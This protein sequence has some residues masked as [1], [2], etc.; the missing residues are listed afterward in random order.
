MRGGEE[1]FRNAYQ[2]LGLGEPSPNGHKKPEAGINPLLAG[3]VLLDGILRDGAPPPDEHEKGLLIRGAVHHLYGP[4]AQG[5]SWVTLWLVAR[6]LRRGETVCYFDSE[7]GKRITVERLGELGVTPE[8][9]ANLHYWPDGGDLTLDPASRHNYREVLEV[10][11]PDLIL[12]DALIYFL[13]NAGVGENDPDGI[14]AWSLAFTR[15]ARE[16]GITT[17]LVD[18]TGHDESRARG[19]S[20]KRQEM[21]VQWSVKATQPFDR[22]TVGE[23]TLRR[24]KDRES[25]LPE[26]LKF[27]AGGT[28]DGFLI[29]PSVGTIEDVAHGEGLT[30]SA[31]RALQ[32]LRE[33][34]GLTYNEWR[35]L[36]AE[37]GVP[38]GSFG[39]VVRERLKAHPAHVYLKESRYYPTEGPGSSDTGSDT[40]EN[41][42]EP[43]ATQPDDTYRDTG[44]SRIDNGNNPERYHEY[45]ETGISDTCVERG[46]RYHGITPLIGGVPDT[47]PHHRY[48][49]PEPPDG[50]ND[51]DDWEPSVMH[52]ADILGRGDDVEYF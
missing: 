47:E 18:H 16:M 11:K 2:S 50:G 5:K 45:H 3:R 46:G 25:W 15:T 10:L 23:I 34:P 27:S 6:A 35:T 41:P 7:N 8:E 42:P 1:S 36:A 20:R 14:V 30:P 4:S 26:V 51:E 48:R 39:R 37:N 12:F 43:P 49:T 32:V 17:I 33:R 31:F 19:S 38:K 40:A 29:Q 24:E 28:E 9:V 44:E 52:A 21:D 13:T 22:N